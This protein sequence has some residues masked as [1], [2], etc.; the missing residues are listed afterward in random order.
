MKR[1]GRTRLEIKDAA[2]W[3]GVIYVMK[4]N[5]L[6]SLRKRAFHASPCWVGKLVMH[7]VALTG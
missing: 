7:A 2:L 5:D 1:A 6:P 3:A 4:G